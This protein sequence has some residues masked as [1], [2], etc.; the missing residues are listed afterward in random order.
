MP[1]SKRGAGV[2]FCSGSAAAT[3]GLLATA[4]VGTPLAR[5]GITLTEDIA[6]R[7]RAEVLSD[8]AHDPVV[9][10]Y[11][12][13]D[14]EK[15]FGIKGAKTIGFAKSGL[16]QSIHAELKEHRINQ[17]VTPTKP[18][19]LPPI[20]PSARKAAPSSPSRRLGRF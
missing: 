8:F 18:P 4:G 2:G 10:H 15:F 12:A 14:L 1:L 17:P 6:E 13:E 3:P 11:V 19:G 16:A 7:V 20:L 9:Q 5:L